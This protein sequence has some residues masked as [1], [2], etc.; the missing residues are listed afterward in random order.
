MMKSPDTPSMV[1]DCPW[2]LNAYF[3]FLIPFIAVGITAAVIVTREVQAMRATNNV[4]S[5]TV[6][7][8][9]ID[10]GSS[11]L[12]KYNAE[13]SRDNTALWLDVMTVAN[14]EY[15]RLQRSNFSYVLHSGSASQIRDDGLEWGQSVGEFSPERLKQFLDDFSAL[16]AKIKLAC[17]DRRPVWVPVETNIEERF[18]SI[19]RPLDSVYRVQSLLALEVEYALQTRDAKRAIEALD[20][21]S[22]LPGLFTPPNGWVVYQFRFSNCQI[23]RSALLQSLRRDIW[24]EDQLETMRLQLNRSVVPLDPDTWPDLFEQNKQLLLQPR[25]YSRHL[26]TPE[27]ATMQLLQVPSFRKRIDEVTEIAK[28]VSEGGLEQLEQRAYDFD[29]TIGYQMDRVE[30]DVIF[31]NASVTG[32]ANAFVYAENERRM[33]ATALALRVFRTRFGKW[34]ENIDELVDVGLGQNELHHLD[35]MRFGYSFDNEENGLARLWN[36]RFGE[37]SVADSFF[38]EHRSTATGIGPLPADRILWHRGIATYEDPVTKAGASVIGTGIEL[39]AA[40]EQSRD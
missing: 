6:V 31:H 35:G 5:A 10:R 30:Y 2:Y 19:G 24:T 37:R 25:G 40:S 33:L 14:G 1:R 18:R 15:A 4:A 28:H 3:W 16:I 29:Q 32:I 34:P 27:V 7:P 36:V 13:A 20:A 39:E 17:S 38:F 9:K 26:S 21:M 22:V 23:Y 8:R 11:R 12:E